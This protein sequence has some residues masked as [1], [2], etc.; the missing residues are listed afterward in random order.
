M[1]KATKTAKKKPVSKKT[2]RK[3]KIS[4]K[5]APK[6]TVKKKA[7][8]NPVIPSAGN[9]EKA[10]KT[11]G[12]ITEVVIRMYCHGFGDCFL[13][14]YMS[15]G[16]PAYRMLIDCGMLTGDSDRLK[17]CIENIKTECNNHLDL[18]VQSHEHKDHIRGI[19]TLVKKH[20]IPVFI[21]DTTKRYGRLTLQKNLVH[22]FDAH[23]PVT[24]GD[25]VVTAFPKFHDA[26]D[27]YSFIIS[28]NNVNV[29]VFTDIGAP[30]EH[31][32]KHFKQCHA[33]FLEA[34]YDELML[35]QGSYPYFLKSR[36]RGGMGHLS[37]MQALE[38][39]RAHR[40]PFM[41]HLF[42]SHLSK[43]NNCPLLVE[44]L[45]RDHAGDVNM[46]VASRYQETSV[47]HIQQPAKVNWHES[48]PQQSCVSYK[49]LT[50]SFT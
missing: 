16:L 10:G 47:F 45:F 18:V 39:F 49:Q 7:T 38:L 27:P 8:V 2:V 9:A 32:I 31:V 12:K 44:K 4:K 28:C 24:I 29:G 33:A 36:I 23:D 5:P 1:A 30:C 37:N 41:T 34:N 50:F 6:K 11:T 35:A 48:K 40:P 22:S 19:Q 42:L 3:K 14:T 17:Q 43:N 46:I 25:L 13:L 26:S 15:G 20:Q 21:T